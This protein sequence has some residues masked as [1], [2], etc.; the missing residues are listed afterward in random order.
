MSSGKMIGKMI[1]SAGQ[2]F[3]TFKLMIAAVVA[4]AILGILLSILGSIPVPGLG[5]SDTAPSLLARA[6]QLQ[7]NVF[8]SQGEVQ[9]QSGEQYIS[10]AFS[11]STGGK[12]VSYECGAG[13]PCGDATA[14]SSSQ[15]AVTGSFKSKI[16][17]C[18]TSASCKVNIGKQDG[19]CPTS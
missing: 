4:V 8:P 15:L 6:N 12:S 16:Y 2:A 19:V 10:S 3:D 7:G 9:F 17:A 14:S 11:S 5:F 13:L 1:G 18:C